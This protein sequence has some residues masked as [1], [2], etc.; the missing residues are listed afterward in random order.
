MTIQIG[1]NQAAKKAKISEIVRRERD[2]RVSL[3][4]LFNGNIF[5]A[6]QE[7]IT[8]ITG[9]GSSAGIAAAM[10]AVAGNFR[11]ADPD[12]DFAWLAKDNQ[13]VL[14]DAPTCFQFSQAAMQHKSTHIFAARAIKDAVPL[15]VDVTDD[16]LWPPKPSV[17]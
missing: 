14:M 15:P 10:G 7:S 12:T 8:N 13:I 11:W 16:S 17:E 4:F 2:Y 5:D 9:A 1:I 6:D 3:G